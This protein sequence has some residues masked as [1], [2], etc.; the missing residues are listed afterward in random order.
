MVV[1]PRAGRFIM[2]GHSPDLEA[3]GAPE[4]SPRAPGSATIEI[5]NPGRLLGDQ[6]LMWLKDKSRQALGQVKHRGGEVRV[7][8]VGDA[9][10][11]Q[12]HKRFSG[13]EGTTDVLT[14]DLSEGATAKGGPLDADILICVDE[15]RRHASAH[16]PP[17][18]V[19]HEI[20]LY[21]LHGVL[22]CLGHD[23]ETD[24][25]SMER[26]ERKLRRRWLDA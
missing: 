21:I 20:L 11:A 1:G 16:T 13:V 10:M 22:H 23:H 4:D 12:D 9:E 6:P 8:L 3:H 26:L 7:R 5:A 24:G 17:H 14:F 19:E 18:P 15:A 2:A 25:G